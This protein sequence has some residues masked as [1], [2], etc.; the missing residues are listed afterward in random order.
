M[1]F[2]QAFSLSVST[3]SALPSSLMCLTSESISLSEQV[4]PV[5]F[6]I[7]R[8]SHARL[9]ISSKTVREGEIVKVELICISASWK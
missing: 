1:D 3:H 7:S 4:N 9:K 8:A 6:S 2:P 5:K